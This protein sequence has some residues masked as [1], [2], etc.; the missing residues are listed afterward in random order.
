MF[1]LEALPMAVSG[2]GAIR[3]LSSLLHSTP[4]TGA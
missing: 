3:R 1:K 2:S 4:T